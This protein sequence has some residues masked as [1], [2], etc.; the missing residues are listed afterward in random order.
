MT[1]LVAGSRIRN[2]A[3]APKGHEAI[4]WVRSH[5][6]V[7]EGF[8]RRRLDDGRL[9]GRRIILLAH[10]DAKSAFVATVLADAGARVVVAGSN[11]LTIRDDVAAALVD[12]GVEVHGSRHSP[13]DVWES[14][15]MAAIATD[16]E[17]VIDDGAELTMRIARR[18]RDLY[19][20]VLGVTENTTSGLARLRELDRACDLP[21]PAIAT[22]HHQFDNRFGTAQSAIQAILRLTNLR[23]PGKR[24][25]VVGYGPVGRGLATYVRSL[26]GQVTV[27]EI[28]ST[29]AFEALADGH[30]VANLTAAVAGANIVI[31]ATGGPGVI[32]ELHLSALSPMT[33]LA[34][35]GQHDLAIDVP[36]LAASS[37]SP[38]EVRPGVTRYQLDGERP[39][40]LLCGGVSVNHASGL[41]H[42]IE[43][44]DLTSSVQVLACHLLASG[45]L[46][47]GVHDFPSELTR[48]IATA[49]LQSRGIGPVDRHLDLST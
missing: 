16:P 7:L 9:V 39:V 18:R 26:G 17:L 27:V 32:S 6:P 25:V 43:T 4:E 1:D 5:S 36:T 24:V 3:L 29:R 48:A 35:A 41:G 42:P 37:A 19:A 38:E 40:Y 28:D 44:M 30:R 23:M 10:L 31:T 15:V 21:M 12:R 47:P 45:G 46:G 13:A 20:R 49:Q 34:N 14:D 33:I 11:P 2:I 8:V 22:S